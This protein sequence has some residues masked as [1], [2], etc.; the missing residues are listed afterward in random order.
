MLSESQAAQPSDPC[1]LLNKVG[2]ILV[3]W[4]LWLYPAIAKSRIA[5]ILELALA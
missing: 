3:G 4:E 5:A 1:N 2:S